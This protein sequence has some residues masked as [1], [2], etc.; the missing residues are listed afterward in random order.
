MNKSWILIPE[1]EIRNLEAFE[2]EFF[3]VWPFFCMRPQWLLLRIEFHKT[4]KNEY[5]APARFPSRSSG[6]FI[7][8]C[9]F[10]GTFSIKLCVYKENYLIQMSDVVSKRFSSLF[11]QLGR[12]YMQITFEI[13]FLMPVH[14]AHI[15]SQRTVY[16]I[17]MNCCFY[18]YFSAHGLQPIVKW[19]VFGFWHFEMENI[20]MFWHYDLKWL[21]WRWLLLLLLLLFVF[22]LPKTIYR[23][24]DEKQWQKCRYEW[25]TGQTICQLFAKTSVEVVEL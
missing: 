25:H 17:C 6:F 5:N 24:G 20:I 11:F 15:N 16:L 22:H 12:R 13:S 8:M 9:L 7:C 2:F 14:S 18:Y 10:F 21:L 4:V 3:S 1:S 23:N 19:N